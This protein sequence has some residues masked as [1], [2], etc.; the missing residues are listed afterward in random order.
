MSA[1]KCR[2]HRLSSGEWRVAGWFIFSFRSLSTPANSLSVRARRLTCTSTRDAMLATSAASVVVSS[3]A[4]VALGRARRS[5]TTATSTTNTVRAASQLGH[6]QPSRAMRARARRSRGGGL[7]TAAA[8]AEQGELGQEA[9]NQDP[10][11]TL[12]QKLAAALEVGQDTM[13]WMTWRA[14]TGTRC[15]IP[16]TC[17]PHPHITAPPVTSHGGSMSSSTTPRAT[18]TAGS[19]GVRR[20]CV[21]AASVCQMLR[22]GDG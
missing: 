18:C 21:C 8:A 4:A 20:A 22:R 3:G 6:G 14:S 1:A 10:A 7:A 13:Y 12:E 9:W 5:A 15:L 2:R 17:Q 16:A 11:L 19:C